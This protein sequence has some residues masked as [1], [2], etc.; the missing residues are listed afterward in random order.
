MHSERDAG[1]F[2]P[3]AGGGGVWWGI[4]GGNVRGVY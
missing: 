1:W 4:E 2:V 3:Q